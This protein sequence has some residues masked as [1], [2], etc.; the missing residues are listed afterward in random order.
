MRRFPFLLALGTSIALFAAPVAQ[1]HHPGLDPRDGIAS[2]GISETVISGGESSKLISHADDPSMLSDATTRGL[3]RALAASA[4]PAEWCGAQ[5]SVDNT[6]N[7]AYPASSPQFKL[8]YAYPV[9]RPNR[10]AAAS[11]WIQSTVSMI[12]SYYSQSS[13]GTR[14]VRFDMGT[15]CGPQFVD[16]AV[17][18]LPAAS[19]YYFNGGEVQFNA[20]TQH[21]EAALGTATGPRNTLTFLDGIP[22]TSYRGVGEL[23]PQASEPDATNVHNTGG[24]QSMVAIPA[25][26]SSPRIDGLAAITA[27]EI[28]HNLGAVLSAAPHSSPYGHCWDE[29]D[30]MCYA[31]GGPHDL[32][33]LC[34]P[35]SGLFA[36]IEAL[37]CGGD[38][39]FN[40]APAPGSY[41]T[42]HWNTYNNVFLTQCNPGDG[43]C[44][45]AVP[46]PVVAPQ[47]DRAKTPLRL[48]AGGKTRS[49][50]DTRFTR[51]ADGLTT[52]TVEAKNLRLRKGSWRIRTCLRFQ[53]KV[54][55]APGDY[56]R[57]HQLA[58]PGAKHAARLKFSVTSNQL[59]RA[60]V[61]GRKIVRGYVTVERRERK[62]WKPYMD[63]VAK[64]GQLL[65]L[66]GG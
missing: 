57:C 23:F 53:R 43:A 22:G 7:A 50:A 39:Y 27:H 41:L 44:E 16:I 10:F 19:T 4:V 2:T 48:V 55:E 65:E 12:S 5:T 8:V 38:D 32:S 62:R 30:L 56:K 59:E 46:D 54:A 51:A 42:S 26:V 64:R 49:F 60:P 37:D 35:L 20:L 63:Y 66:A 15:S 13:G 1:A 6:V 33:I 21:V 29:R 61:A 31:D 58:G 28:G 45:P 34:A 25:D 24:L 52:L 11:N 9:D 14:I 17:V 3:A 47:S 40:P 18:A 36:T